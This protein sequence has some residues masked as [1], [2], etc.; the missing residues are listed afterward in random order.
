MAIGKLGDV[1]ID[2]IATKGQEKQYIQVCYLLASKATIQ[3]EFSALTALPDNYPK[4][5]L[6]L[7]P[8]SP[9]NLEGIKWQNI[10]EFLMS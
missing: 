8:I 10:I 1:E 6:S 2:F 4:T 3:R 7:D 5:V 9:D